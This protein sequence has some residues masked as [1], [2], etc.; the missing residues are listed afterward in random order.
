MRWMVVLILWTCCSD[1]VAEESSASIDV[2]AK[3]KNPFGVEIAG[4]RLWL[5]SVDSQRVYESDVDGANAVIVAGNGTKGYS[6]DGGPADKASMNWPHEVRRDSQGNLFIAD[7]RNHVIRRVDTETGFITTIA[8]TGVE[9]FSGDGGPAAAAQL[10]LPHSVVLL[11]DETLLVADTGNHRLRQIDLRSGKIETISGNGEKRL[12]ADGAAAIKA[13]LFGPR[14]V[15]VAPDTIWIAL[16]EGNSIW[17]ID[18]RDGTIHHVAGTGE[19]GYTGDGG[20]PELAT[21]RGPKGL[22]IDARGR[23][24]VVDTENHAVRR[25]DLDGKLVETVL[26]GTAAESTTTL[27]RPHGIHGLPSGGFIVADSENDRVLI[28]RD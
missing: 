17:R 12:P 24:L 16:R 2:I 25:I 23:L 22:T 3:W 4:G 14:A 8:G 18:R 13:P 7:T 15:A 6:G 21:F 27:Q 19:K 1:L 26:G 9:G 5:T 11:N 20:P 10:R 28:Y